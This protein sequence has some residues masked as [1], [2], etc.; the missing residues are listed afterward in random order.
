MRSNGKTGN[1]A[2]RICS[3]GMRAAYS[4]LFTA[5]AV[6]LLCS[7]C[8]D[9]FGILLKDINNTGSP[10]SSVVQV[11]PAQFVFSSVWVGRNSETTFSLTNTCE[12]AV[13]LNSII[14]SDET[15]YEIIS[16][17]VSP[18]TPGSS[19]TLTI[20]FIP[21][22]VGIKP[23]TVT[24]THNREGSPMVINVSGTG[25]GEILWTETDKTINCTN[26]DRTGS[27][28]LLTV[29]GTPLDIDLYM[30][31]ESIYWTEYTGSGTTCQIRMADIDGSSE[32]LFHGPS[33]LSFGP[34]A[35][36]IDYGTGIIYWN[37]Y[38]TSTTQNDIWRSPLSAFSAVQW[39]KTLSYNYSHSIC[40]D[41]ANSRIYGSVNSYWEI[42]GG[43]GS[44]NNG[45]IF[46]GDLG[47]GSFSQP[48][49]GTGPSGNSSALRGIAADSTGPVDYIFFVNI[50]TSGNQ[51]IRRAL[52][53][54]LN[55]NTEFIAA[56]ANGIQKIALDL[57]GRKIY[58]TTASGNY[59]YRADLDTSNSN[60][61]LFLSLDSKPNG[62][63]IV[64]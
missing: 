38:N 4:A 52:S 26:R 32:N 28:T 34:S 9:E 2:G 13:V 25:I 62:I 11:S 7:G 5:C 59:I 43:S 35:I 53:G 45:V 30:P 17:P 18:I 42:Y 49:S 47:T 33:G 6:L 10:V 61:E 36:A 22:S 40:L 29:A 37:E 58:W 24:I 20:R 19:A 15:N 55:T 39:V 57:T 16:Y 51:T 46:D 60:I 48:V 23:A 64:P 63:V 56:Q 1:F 31:D 50:D 14:L 12:D 27:R 3:S 8:G 21:V 44:G 41:T 54:N